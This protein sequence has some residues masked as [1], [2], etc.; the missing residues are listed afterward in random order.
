M[1]VKWWKGKYLSYSMAEKAYKVKK[2]KFA[3][4]SDLR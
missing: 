2:M 1:E 3:D 4:G